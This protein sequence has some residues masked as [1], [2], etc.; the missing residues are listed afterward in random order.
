MKV[1][2]A[3]LMPTQLVTAMLMR[4]RRVMFPRPLTRSLTPS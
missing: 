2:M 1:P 3:V 4:L